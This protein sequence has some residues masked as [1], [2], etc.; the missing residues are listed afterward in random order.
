MFTRV[1]RIDS[2][3]LLKK[4]WRDNDS[5]SGLVENITVSLTIFSDPVSLAPLLCP[6]WYDARLSEQNYFKGN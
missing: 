6:H 5:A 2:S 1:T 3:N 4:R